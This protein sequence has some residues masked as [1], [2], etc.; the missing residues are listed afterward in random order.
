MTEYFDKDTFSF[1]WNDTN[2]AVGWTRSGTFSGT[3]ALIK[4]FPDGECWIFVTNTS[5]WKGPSFSRI[6]ASLFSE[7][8]RGWGDKFPKQDLFHE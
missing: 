8:R 2:P 1:G 3:S 7:L 4:Y 6:T 5:T